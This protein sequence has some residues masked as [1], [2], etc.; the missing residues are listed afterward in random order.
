MG[1]GGG[2]GGG[3]YGGGGGGYGGGGY[4]GGGYGGGG[5]DDGLALVSCCT[6]LVLDTPCD[7]DRRVRRRRRRLRRWRVRRWRTVLE[8]HQAK[9]RGTARGLRASTRVLRPSAS[10]SRMREESAHPQFRSASGARSL[11]ADC[12]RARV[13]LFGHG[14]RCLHVNKTKSRLIRANTCSSASRRRA[15]R[16]TLGTHR[17]PSHGDTHTR[18]RRDPGASDPPV[19]PFP[20]VQLVPSRGATLAGRGVPSEPRLRLRG[21]ELSHPA[22]SVKSETHPA[23]TIQA[24]RGWARRGTRSSQARVPWARSTGD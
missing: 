22:P 13:Y 4:G 16:G 17:H 12:R 9:F 8:A 14:R 20:R 15:V 19:T 1:G 7:S 21:E 2:Y 18:T 24:L 6:V 5:G 23:G 10:R 11:S 3:G